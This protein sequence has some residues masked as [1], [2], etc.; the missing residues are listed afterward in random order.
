MY[1]ITAFDCGNTTSGVV[2]ADVQDDE[3]TIL[4]MDVIAMKDKTTLGKYIEDEL[5]E[6]M[7]GDNMLVVYENMCFFNNWNLMRIQRELKEFCEKQGY[8]TRCLLPSQKYNMI[9]GVNAQRKKKAVEV[10]RNLLS[11]EWLDKFNAFD[12]NH[13]VADA[14]LMIKY[15]VDHPDKREVKKKRVPKSNSLGIKKKTMKKT[16]K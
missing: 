7:K 11:G 14:L 15:L 2:V 1:R 9:S 10:A 5:G 12:R 16:K 4:H 3:M 13:D 8:P 6:L